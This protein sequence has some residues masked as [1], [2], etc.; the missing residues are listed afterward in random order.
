VVGEISKQFGQFSKQQRQ[1]LV[2]PFISMF[3]AIILA[4]DSQTQPIVVTLLANNDLLGSDR[5]VGHPGAKIRH[6]KKPAHVPA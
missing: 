4:P 6:K 3:T 2:N 1:R 5:L